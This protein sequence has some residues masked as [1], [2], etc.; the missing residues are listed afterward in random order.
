[1]FVLFQIFFT[2]GNKTFLL[3]LFCFVVYVTAK[4]YFYVEYTLY[5]YSVYKV[6]FK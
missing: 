6:Y 2:A 3:F 1:M 4:V 5:N